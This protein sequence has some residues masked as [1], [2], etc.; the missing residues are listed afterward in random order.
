MI[1]VFDILDRMH[2]AMKYQACQLY[3]THIQYQSSSMDDQSIFW[4]KID[5]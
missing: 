2:K 3:I 5:K 4:T 1:A